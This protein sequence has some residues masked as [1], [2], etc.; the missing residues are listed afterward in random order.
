MLGKIILLI[1]DNPDHQDLVQRALRKEG[2]PHLCVAVKDVDEAMDFLHARGG[3]EERDRK[4]TPGLV[5]VDLKLARSHGNDV[6]RALRK[7]AATR[8]VPAVVLTSSVEQRDVEASYEAG[9]NAYVRKEI[10]FDDFA[11]NLRATVTFWLDVN[12]APEVPVR[13]KAGR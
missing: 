6:I 11:R 4:L 12:V 10:D 2:V 1:E 8:H 9:A 5:L 3:W 7:D 13:T